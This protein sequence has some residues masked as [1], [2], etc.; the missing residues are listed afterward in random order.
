M[1]EMDT[2]A[3]KWCFTFYDQRSVNDQR[4]FS[5]FCWLGKHLVKY[6]QLLSQLVLIIEV[7]AS[8]AL[9][10]LGGGGLILTHLVHQSCH[11]NLAGLQICVLGFNRPLAK[12]LDL[13]QN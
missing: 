6:H 3:Q 7:M 2:Q 4:L 9:A 8:I 12:S 11:I 13:A 10:T 1:I 5:L